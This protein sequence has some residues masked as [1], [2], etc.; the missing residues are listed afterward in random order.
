LI[1][2]KCGFNESHLTYA[3]GHHAHATVG[4]FAPYLRFKGF[5][6]K[7]K[8]SALSFVTSSV[9]DFVKLVAVFL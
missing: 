5:S 6:L 3:E 1:S 8:F 4:F 7:Y 2:D 9:I